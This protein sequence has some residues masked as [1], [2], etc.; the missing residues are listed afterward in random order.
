[1]AFPVALFGLLSLP[2]VTQEPEK[3]FVTGFHR[4]A[5]LGGVNRKV[6]EE[7]KSHNGL[8]FDLC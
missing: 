5:S 2:Y 4:Y 3:Y 8:I 1:M 6:R 7:E